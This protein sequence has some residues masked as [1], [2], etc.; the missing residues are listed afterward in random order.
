[1]TT[2]VSAVIITLLLLAGYAVPDTIY[3]KGGD[4][5]EGTVLE[6]REDAVIVSLRGLAGSRLEVP[7]SRISD[8]GLYEI[9]R[10]RI[11]PASAADHEKLGDWALDRR[12]FAFAMQEYQTA[13]ELA[14]EPIPEEILRKLRA[15]SV[16]CGTDKLE[17]ADA[18]SEEGLREEARTLY[19]DILANHPDCTAAEEA[20]KRLTALNRRTTAELRAERRAR[21]AEA[22]REDVDKEIGTARALLVEGDAHRRSGQLLSGHLGAA[23][24]AFLLAIEAYH[25]AGNILREL[26]AR[27]EGTNRKE[28]FASLEKSRVAKLLEVF[29][30]IGHN[31]VV[32]GNLIKA[33]HYVGLS[34]AI[35]PNA[36]K[37]LALRDVIG[38]AVGSDRFPR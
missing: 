22:V 9:R 8:Y 1:M 19:E 11:D 3:L 17:R 5:L 35:D 34:L 18:L 15:A 32:K 36:P 20:K 21:A 31:F 29:I 27:P 23:E 6:V 30:D 25:R 13:G 12:L 28:A 16:G 4:A 2:R 14:G 10:R 24:D 33:N 37:A 38:F 7:R 26:E